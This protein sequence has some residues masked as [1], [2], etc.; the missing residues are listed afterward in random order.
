VCDDVDWIEL[1]M[2]RLK[3]VGFCDLVLNFIKVKILFT[4]LFSEKY[5]PNF[6]QTEH[7]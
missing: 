4:N 3:W 7:S 5:I 1:D 2:A 6:Q